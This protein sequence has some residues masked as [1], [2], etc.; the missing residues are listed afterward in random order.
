[1]ERT[2]IH[3]RP[4]T[5]VAA[6]ALL[7]ACLAVGAA[8]AQPAT[9]T[10]PVSRDFA[11]TFADPAVIKA[12]DGYWY[13]YGTT[14]PLREGERRMHTIPISRSTDLVNWTYVGDAF[15]SPTEVSWAAPDGGIWAPDVRY[16]DGKYHMYY[17]VTQTTVT[18]EQHDN[19]IGV[20]TSPTPVG[21]WT[22]SG[23]PV[24]GPRRRGPDNFFWTFDPSAFTDTDGTRYLYYGSYYGGQWVTQL[25]PDG[26]RAV[27]EATQISIGDR[28]EGAYVIRKGDYYYLF[29]SA[30]NCCAGPTTGYSVYAGRATSPRG[31]F[32]DK[33][34]T[35]FLGSRVGGTIVVSMNGNRWVGTGHN[36]VISD[37]S[38]QDW[39]LYHAIDR[40]DPFLDEPYGINERPM[41]IDRLDWVDGWPTVRAGRWASEAAEPAPVTDGAVE[42]T[43]NGRG[44]LG[45]Q[46]VGRRGWH[47]APPA[48]GA[49]TRF[50]ALNAN[51]RGITLMRSAAEAPA[52]RRVEADLRSPAKHGGDIGLVSAWQ[53]GGYVVSWL[54]R[55]RKAMVTEVIVGGKIVQSTSTALPATFR[56]DTWHNVATHLRDGQLSVEVTDSRL[57]DPLARHRLTLPDRFDQADA[58]GVATRSGRGHADNISAAR[59]YDPV[60]SKVADPQVG[61]V[62]PA[63]SD[64]FD[65]ATLEAPW[66]WVRQPDGHQAGGDY[67]WPTQSADL[68]TGSNNA[69]VLLRPAPA[70]DYTVETK[71]KIDLG[72]DTVRNYQQA[73][74]IAYEHDDLYAK[75][76]HVAIWNTRQTEFA[77]E[78]PFAQRIS[79]GGTLIG[80]PADTTW[81]RL[82]HR[83]D[84]DNGEHE[85]RAATSRNG[86]SWVWGG[87]W[88]LPAGAQPRIGLISMGG[89]GATAQFEYFR[90]FTP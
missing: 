57:H 5:T 59:L 63:F 12:K 90:V 83:V 11:D 3:R 16:L 1:M 55:D 54:E 79:Y 50:A 51:R 88:T 4:V 58:V 61:A 43:F 33:E 29:S 74:L 80:P 71:L 32:V 30:A 10:N 86:E 84:P 2:S 72:T 14:D 37:L 76:V 65:D 22:D 75:L 28:Y 68:H 15:D 60:T 64:E 62:Q 26:K 25:S 19:A 70:G 78:M 8:T 7:A 38:G 66:T 47:I 49:E 39:F 45:K 35:S 82:S 67:V 24:V 9:Y 36:A 34:G 69:S 13:A 18:P 52:D 31:P 85:Y 42:D 48:R 27:G 46:W 89:S 77:K 40:N 44:S 23:Q 73:G 20:A 87:V 53:R 6:V 41:L 56:Y 81:L 21:P 17:V